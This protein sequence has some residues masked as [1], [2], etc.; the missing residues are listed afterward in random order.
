MERDRFEKAEKAKRE[1]GVHETAVEVKGSPGTREAPV[2]WFS[3][4]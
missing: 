4:Y 3:A 2:V 1:A